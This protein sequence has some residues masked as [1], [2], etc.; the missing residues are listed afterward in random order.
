MALKFRGTYSSRNCLLDYIKAD[1][2]RL[3]GSLDST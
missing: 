1:E 2:E 3:H